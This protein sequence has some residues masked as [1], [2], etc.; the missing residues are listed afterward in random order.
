VRLPSQPDKRGTII[1]SLISAPRTKTSM[2]EGLTSTGVLLWILGWLFQRY[3]MPYIVRTDSFKKAV[4]VVD[5]GTDI[6]E[7]DADF[8]WKKQPVTAYRPFKPIYHL[9]MGITKSKESEF[10]KIE[11]T[12]LDV[13]QYKSQVAAE[14]PQETCLIAA[15][16]Q[17]S[18]KQ[19]QA[20][21]NAVEELYDYVVGFLLKKYQMHFVATGN[22][23]TNLINNQ[24]FPRYASKRDKKTVTH[25][26]LLRIICGNVEEDF[27]IMQFDPEVQEYQLRALT[28]VA[29]NG[30]RNSEKFGKKL[31]DIHQPVPQYM[32]RLQASMNR[33]FYRIKPHEFMQ[34]LTWGIHV[35]TGMTE[36]YRPSGQHLKPDEKP[37]KVDAKT[38]DIANDVQVRV[39]RQVL[40]KLEK[41]EF[42]VLNVHT[43]MYPLSEIK[44]EGNAALLAKAIRAWPDDTAQYKGRPR[45]A[46]PCLHTSII[47][48]LYI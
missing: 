36:L 48:R 24:E 28:G 23:V 14:E 44:A 15:E 17:V 2:L 45:W 31:T 32:Q 18:K 19:V 10:L 41:S 46:T 26:D 6:V 47:S 25:R 42:I 43:F 3:V 38:T 16:P 33:H 22:T 11:N 35:G 40:T 20:T 29:A 30:F 39:E 37:P 21:E 34:R 5:N 12:Y 1:V 8:D 27:L 13:T 7:S 9:T 4:K